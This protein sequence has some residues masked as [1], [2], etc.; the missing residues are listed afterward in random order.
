MVGTTQEQIISLI[1]RFPD[2]PKE[3]WQEIP[4]LFLKASNKLLHVVN[5]PSGSEQNDPSPNIPKFEL[6]D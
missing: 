4:S 5:Y 1:A 2:S 3:I 6:Q